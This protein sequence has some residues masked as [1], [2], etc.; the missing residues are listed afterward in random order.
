MHKDLSLF[1]RHEDIEERSAHGYDCRRR[2]DA[3]GIGATSGLLN[4]DSSLSAQHVEDC[5]RRL[6]QVCYLNSRI[7]TDDGLRPVRE[8]QHKPPAF[9]SLNHI[10]CDQFIIYT[11]LN[12]HQHRLPLRTAIN[13]DSAAAAQ[14]SGR[15]QSLRT[16]ID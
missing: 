15:D 8:A 5:A 13:L 6:R 11:I 9:V 12:L 14:D 4:L 1:L 10:S 3:I 7:F 2:V 16:S